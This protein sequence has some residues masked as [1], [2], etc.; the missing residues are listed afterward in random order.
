[1]MLLLLNA[2]C[3]RK[4]AISCNSGGKEND[5]LRTTIVRLRHDSDDF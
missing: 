1:M 2:N 3:W 4:F 5:G